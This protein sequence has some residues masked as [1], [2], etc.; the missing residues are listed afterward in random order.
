MTLRLE[1]YESEPDF[2]PWDQQGPG[3][4]YVRNL[5]LR[6]AK[7]RL[8]FVLVEELTAGKLFAT[9][10][11]DS[12]PLDQPATRILA[13]RW[14][15]IEPDFDQSAASARGLVV[16]GILVFSPQFALS[17]DEKKEARR[18]FSQAELRRWYQK[19]VELN[20]EEGHTPSREVDRQAAAAEFG[21]PIPREVVRRLR[22]ELAPEAWVRQGRRKNPKAGS[23]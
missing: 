9:G 19:W 18:G 21:R 4:Y 14:R 17:A 8:Q 13:D 16:T 11:S 1:G 6:Q 23:P 22:R 15:T 7:L 20:Q 2:D 10:Y 5:R 12:A 3:E